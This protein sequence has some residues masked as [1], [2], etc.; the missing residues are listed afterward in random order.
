MKRMTERA[1]TLT[2]RMSDEELAKA[3]AVAAAGDESIGRY[4]RRVV[5][6]DYE[7]R[8]GEAPPPRAKLRPG[9]RRPKGGE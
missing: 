8:F 7:R 6:S 5:T 4:L 1:R 3:H 9:P 2:I